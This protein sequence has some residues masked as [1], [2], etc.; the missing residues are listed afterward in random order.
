MFI[1][2][3]VKPTKGLRPTGGTALLYYH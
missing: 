3:H 1:G 2:T